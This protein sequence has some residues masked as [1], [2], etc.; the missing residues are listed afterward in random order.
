MTNETGLSWPLMIYTQ[1][2][3]K[4]YYI[5]ADSSQKTYVKRSEG[6]SGLNK[7]LISMD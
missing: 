4:R 3:V 1:K 7:L 5:L 6:S 2:W